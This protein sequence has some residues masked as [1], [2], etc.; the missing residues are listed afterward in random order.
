VISG[1]RREVDETCVLPGYYVA[2]NGNSLPTFRDNLSVPFSSFKN[3]LG[4]RGNVFEISVSTN[5]TVQRQNPQRLTLNHERIV[6]LS[7][8]QTKIV[9]K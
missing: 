5:E 2:S 7:R 1:I 3:L 4:F 8:F 6:Y 9:K